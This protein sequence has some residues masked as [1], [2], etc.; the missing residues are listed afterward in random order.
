MNTSIEYQPRKDLQYSSLKIHIKNFKYDSTYLNTIRRIL[1]E[2]I[3]IYAFDR[4]YINITKN[5]NYQNSSQLSLRLSQI[6]VLGIKTDLLYIDESRYKDI[7]YLR[8]PEYPDEKIYEVSI[9]LKND[10][11]EF[12]SLTTNNFSIFID[13]KQIENPYNKEYPL[14]ITRLRPGEEVIGHMRAKIR[15]GILHNIWNPVYNTWLYD[16][17]DKDYTF[18]I[19]S[20]GQKTEQELFIQ[21]IDVILDKINNRLKD[22]LYN[23]TNREQESLTNYKFIIKDK[24]IAN[25]LSKTLVKYD[26]VLFVGTAIQS[27]LDPAVELH[28]TLKENTNLNKLLDKSIKDINTIYNEIKESFNKANK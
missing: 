16:N 13:G 10:T 23:E 14:L 25:I 9:N 3:P 28:L 12:M 18:I 22:E 11:K 8:E 1:M 7:D 15:L 4:K 27:Y 19:H 17:N 20:Y 26:E 2:Y 24:S 6:P 5:T 21:A